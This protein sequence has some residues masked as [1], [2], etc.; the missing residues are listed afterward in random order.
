MIDKPQD[1]GVEINWTPEMLK[2]FK[3]TYDEAVAMKLD[4]FK[5]DGN[6]FVTGYA[7]YLIEY[8]DGEFKKK[9]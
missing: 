3:K 4:S 9:G 7:K 8:L 1:E 5:F 6:V 2:R